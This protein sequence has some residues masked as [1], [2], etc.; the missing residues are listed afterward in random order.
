MA[1]LQVGTRAASQLNAGVSILAAA[2]TVYTRLI[3]ARLAGFERA[4]RA[5]GAADDRVRAA[6]AQ[7][8]AAQTRLGELD[9]DQDEAVDAVARALIVDGRARTNPFTGFAP[10]APGQLMKLPIADEVQAIH[11]LVAAVERA[12]GLGKPT[13]QAAQAAEK[14]AQAVEQGLAQID[15]LQGIVR[16]ARHTRDAVAQT[17][18]TALAA[19]KRGARAAADDGAPTLY[20]SLFDRPARPNG[21]PNGRSN[22]KSHKPPVPAPSPPAPQPVATAAS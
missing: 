14:A 8:S 18:A 15:K 22:G 7:L 17:W 5:Y 3:K 16:E 21:K 1:T 20:A 10:L 4:Q 19:L 12:K 13:L 6:E 9:V 11:Q 2:R